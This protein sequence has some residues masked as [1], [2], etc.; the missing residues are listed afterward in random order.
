MTINVFTSLETAFDDSVLQT[1][2]S[3]SSQIISLISPLVSAAF[4]IYVL[5]VLVS[6]MRGREDLPIV[7]FLMKAGGWMV[8]LTCGM[9]IQYYSQYVVPFFNGFGDDIAKAITHG[10]SG[11]SALDNLLTLYVTAITNMFANADAGLNI[12][13]WLQLFGI[14][15]LLLV[16]GVLFLGIACAFIILSKFALGLL[17][18]LGPMFI[19]CALFP[20]TKRFFDAWIGQCVNYGLLVAL[21][22]AAG[23]IEVTF[24][25]SNLPQN[26]SLQGTV[27]TWMTSAKILASGVVFIIISLNLP[28]LASQ[29]AGG[30]GISSM[31][32]NMGGAAKAAMA[33][34]R[35]L[36][37][38]GGGKGGSLGKA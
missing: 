18:A 20:P 15:I 12:G 23:A 34:M 33:A 14:S 13:L 28:S 3:G 35:R 9:N 27:V 37:G 38:G 25:T 1:I 7:D 19:A 24:A 2:N 11:M 29:L 17:L 22:G 4:G 16:P 26:F 6:Y 32:G 8:V 30:V 10:N 5:L 31:V 21:Y 36:G